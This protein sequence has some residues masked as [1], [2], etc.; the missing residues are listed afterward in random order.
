MD[1]SNLVIIKYMTVPEKYFDSINTQ[2]EYTVSLVPSASDKYLSARRIINPHINNETKFSYVGQ[3]M[4]YSSKLTCKKK[5]PWPIRWFYSKK[6][7]Y[8]ILKDPF[9]EALNSYERK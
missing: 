3:G 9:E 8:I 7:K 6:N 5:R 1:S 4:Y 2:K